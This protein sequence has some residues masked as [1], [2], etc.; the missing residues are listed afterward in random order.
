MNKDGEYIKV[1][2]DTN[3]QQLFMDEAIEN[4]KL[5]SIPKMVKRNK[6]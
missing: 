2:G 5:K 3:I 6:I 4:Y 1:E